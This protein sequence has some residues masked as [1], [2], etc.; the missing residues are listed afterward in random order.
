MSSLQIQD[1][2]EPYYAG[3]EAGD[4]S[5]V[6]KGDALKPR[7]VAEQSNIIRRGQLERAS[8]RLGL[9]ARRKAARES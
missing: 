2:F 9:L 1:T 7:N 3:R 4:T 8:R 6:T 5:D